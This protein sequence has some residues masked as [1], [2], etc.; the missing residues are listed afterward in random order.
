MD[1]K[2][3][4]VLGEVYKKMLEIETLLEDNDMMHRVMSIMMLG[5]ISEEDME[6]ENEFSEMKAIYNFNILNKE[7]LETVINTV[8]DAYRKEDGLSDLLDGTGISLN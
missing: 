8:R 1:E 6:S 3:A 5:V 7:E 4:N 2:D